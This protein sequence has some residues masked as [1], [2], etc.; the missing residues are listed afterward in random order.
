MMTELKKITHG[1]GCYKEE[2]QDGL[3]TAEK[4][5]ICNHPIRYFLRHIQKMKVRQ[6]N[7]LTKTLLF[8]F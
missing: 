5:L 6:V 7:N 3:L 1:N 8:A 2:F 4:C